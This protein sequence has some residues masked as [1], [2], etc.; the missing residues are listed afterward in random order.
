LRCGGSIAKH[1]ALGNEVHVLI[2]A[3]GL[4]SRDAKRNIE[5]HSDE[6][7]ELAKAEQRAN[8]IL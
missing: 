1:S 2:L 6:L 5:H 4:T 3:E 7:T 8:N